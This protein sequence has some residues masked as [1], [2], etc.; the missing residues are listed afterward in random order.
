MVSIR[1]LLLVACVGVVT[2]Q[3]GGSNGPSCTD[4]GV[5]DKPSCDDY[6]GGDGGHMPSSIWVADS[7]HC[8]CQNCMLRDCLGHSAGCAVPDDGTLPSGAM[9]DPIVDTSHARLNTPP[10]LSF[11][12][13]S[14]VTC[15]PHTSLTH[16]PPACSAKRCQQH[17]RFRWRRV[18]WYPVLGGAGNHARTALEAGMQ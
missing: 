2:A 17:Q 8:I 1:A 6:C 16:T 13:P 3:L 9:H 18:P 11:P 15:M 14:K 12:E 4:V 7:G 10:T 5:D